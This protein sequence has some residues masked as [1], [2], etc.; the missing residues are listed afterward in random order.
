MLRGLGALAAF[1]AIVPSS[2]LGKAAPSNRITI[3]MVG[4]GRQALHANLKP[5]LFS[6]D[7]EVI[8]LLTQPGCSSRKHGREKKQAFRRIVSEI[9]SP[10]RVTRALSSMPKHALV[11]NHYALRADNIGS[12][13]GTFRNWVLEGSSDGAAWFVLR[14]H[15]NDTS[16]SK[17]MGVVSWALDGATVGGRA[18][19][20][21]R[22][23]STGKCS[24]G[25][26]EC[27][28]CAGI[29]L[30]GQLSVD[31]QLTKRTRYRTVHNWEERY[32]GDEWGVGKQPSVLYLI[33]EMS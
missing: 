31:G 24:T 11:P 7:A 6:D 16:S 12:G 28:S 4:M 22:V 29:E 2:V 15:S 14:E 20:H 17:S 5:F 27:F 18:F 26:Y 1:P 13:S 21:F 19:R 25:S 10:P 8:G 30:Y 3:G 33:W 32:M 23:R 9:Y